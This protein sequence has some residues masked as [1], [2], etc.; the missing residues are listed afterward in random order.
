MCELHPHHT[1]GDYR[2]VVQ[3]LRLPRRRE[4]PM[5]LADLSS[6]GQRGLSVN[7]DRVFDFRPG[8]GYCQKRDP[9]QSQPHPLT[10][11]VWLVD[12]KRARTRPV[13]TLQAIWAA[14]AHAFPNADHK[15]CVNH[16]TL[17]PAADR[18]VLLAR[19]FPDG[20]HEA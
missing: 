7:F 14:M 1:A 2:G 11:G 15:I 10:D 13:L 18:F 3:N 19:T 8:Y 4:L 12:V 17:N 9:G 6:D 16:L 20:F 5:P